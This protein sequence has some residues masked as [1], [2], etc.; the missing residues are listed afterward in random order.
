MSARFMYPARYGRTSFAND[1]LRHGRRPVLE[2]LLWTV[3]LKRAHFTNHL[4]GK[5]NTT[6]LWYGGLL[7]S[8]KMDGWQRLDT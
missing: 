4:L 3:K 6:L 1:L 2:E 5:N 7:E 8:P